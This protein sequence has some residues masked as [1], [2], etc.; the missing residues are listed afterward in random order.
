MNGFQF[1]PGDTLLDGYTVEKPLGHGG[2]GEVYHARSAAGK[3]VA[4]K[5]IQRFLEVELRGVGHCLNLKH[6]HLVTI[7]DV[8][9]DSD[10][11][12][13]IVM[14]YVAGEGLS[15]A[16]KQHPDGMPVEEALRWFEP[17]CQAVE[18]LHQSGIV[19]RDLKPGNIFDDRGTVKVGDYGLAKFITASKRS[20][21]TQSVGTLHYMAPE[22]GSGRYGREV[23]VYAVGVILYEMLTGHV[24]FDGETPAEILMKHLT[25]PPDLDKLPVAFRGVVARMLAKN[26]ND[27]YGS[28]V[29]AL[30]DLRAKIADH[31]HGE[32]IGEPSRYPAY[33]E[34]IVSRPGVS[35]WLESPL[36]FLR[37]H[38]DR[39]DSTARTS[40]TAPAHRG[41]AISGA[42][43]R[44]PVLGGFCAFLF[45]LTIVGTLLTLGG[46]DDGQ[47]G[48]QFGFIIHFAVAPALAATAF[49]FLLRHSSDDGS[50]STALRR[51]P[52]L[53][54]LCALLLLLPV[55]GGFATLP[56][57]FDDGLTLVFMLGV[58]PA[59]LVATIGFL[60]R[61]D[62]DW[63]ARDRRRPEQFRGFGDEEPPPRERPRNLRPEFAPTIIAGE[64]P[65]GREHGAAVHR[66]PRDPADVRHELSELDR[67]WDEYRSTHLNRNRDGS[68]DV[69]T[70]EGSR[71][72]IA[73]ALGFCALLAAGAV[74]GAIT[75]GTLAFF[76]LMLLAVLVL[77]PILLMPLLRDLRLARVYTRS[78]RNYR[79]LRQ[80][81]LR[82]LP[83][84]ERNA[85][86]QSHA[87]RDSSHVGETA[88]WSADSPVAGSPAGPAVAVKNPPRAATASV[89][90]A[91]P[92]LQFDL[93]F[94]SESAQQRRSDTSALRAAGV[95]VWVA[96]GAAVIALA[97]GYRDPLGVF[98]V[99]A[100]V[101]L[102][103][104]L[105]GLA[106]RGGRRAVAVLVL[107]LAAAA[108][109]FWNSTSGR[110]EYAEARR[111][112]ATEAVAESRPP[113]V[114]FAEYQYH[115]HS[116]EGLTFRCSYPGDWKP[117][118]RLESGLLL[119]QFE[120]PDAA[121]VIEVRQ[122]SDSDIAE[123]RETA[124]TV[125]KT[126]GAFVVTRYL[127]DALRHAARE[128][129]ASNG[130]IS[131]S[132]T[133]SSRAR[134][135]DPIG[136]VYT[137]RFTATDGSNGELIQGL[138]GTWF[139]G[140][141]A[142]HVIGYLREIPR[143]ELDSIDPV[144]ETML[145]SLSVVHPD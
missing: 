18:H 68:F 67:E 45:L 19:H 63:S 30:N 117:D 7:Y 106:I 50:L 31:A 77:V 110:V 59:I 6:P 133:G 140:R 136:G 97:L 98:L 103:T 26:P 71:A 56:G 57:G 91:P 76:T 108:G 87:T 40:G 90:S 55:V 99:A 123:A 74:F 44:R 14:E 115:N 84:E 33:E 61:T 113:A 95:L 2:F 9:P 28:V 83:A 145:S 64:S 114:E 10:G 88:A 5:L 66:A 89:R 82:E 49:G 118:Q 39:A 135:R 8:R 127:H 79:T 119:V 47:P 138:H 38:A 32:A 116:P 4:L 78:Q 104:V 93:Q 121:A 143:S 126:D 16:I 92:R 96:V 111:H 101:I 124:R 41:G 12:Q 17:I 65:D 107:V 48:V 1:K 139:D 52:V 105:A 37:G 27:R 144:F 62:T 130:F 43:R 25:S 58:V 72:A 142:F 131:F 60:M 86:E 94:E 34:S 85:A 54:G 15:Q 13:W 128:Q 141:A 132:E 69:P 125:A 109:L 75:L 51:Q 22:V 100:G 70:V 137:N 29:S 36:G 3:D 134:P 24:P 42:L 81:F 129:L 20:A 120:Q 35:D 112:I 73:V 21:Q 23:D 53:A 80:Q 11:R 102:V 46:W 122:V